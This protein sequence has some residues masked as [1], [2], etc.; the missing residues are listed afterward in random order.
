MESEVKLLEDAV[1]LK[2]QYAGEAGRRRKRAFIAQMFEL[3]RKGNVDKQEMRRTIGREIYEKVKAGTVIKSHNAHHLI[4][5]G[6]AEPVNKASQNRSGFT[7]AQIAAAHA[8]AVRIERAQ[9]LPESFDLNLTD[10][11]VNTR[12]DKQKKNAGK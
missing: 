2:P 3:F 11:E 4:G 1:R 9:A 5:A 10:E 8:A 6:K 12:D 7:D